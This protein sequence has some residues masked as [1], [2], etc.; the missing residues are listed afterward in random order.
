VAADNRFQRRRGPA[1]HRFYISIYDEPA[2]VAGAESPG[3]IVK[4]QAW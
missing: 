1:D 4:N 2:F 3:A